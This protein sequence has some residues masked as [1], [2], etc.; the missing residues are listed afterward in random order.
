MKNKILSI[1]I[2][3]TIGITANAQAKLQLSTTDLLLYKAATVTD[4]QLYGK[5]TFSILPDR[6]LERPSLS[7]FSKIRLG[8][9][10]KIGSGKYWAQLDASLLIKKGP[11]PS[12]DFTYKIKGRFDEF[13]SYWWES[14]YLM[15]SKSGITIDYAAEY[16]YSIEDLRSTKVSWE[17]GCVFRDGPGG[18]PV[19][20]AYAG[21]DILVIHEGKPYRGW[22]KVLIKNSE[23]GAIEAYVGRR[24]IEELTDG[25]QK[26]SLRI[27]QTLPSIPIPA[28][29]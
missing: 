16:G 11:P 7:N 18:R 22:A 26:K 14:V 9:K 21:T 10:L 1:T 29:R 5:G 15:G 4:D 19:A 6:W 2:L 27:K 12:I 20:R 25:R 23:G 17:V 8:G 24:L 3:L 28:E 13:R